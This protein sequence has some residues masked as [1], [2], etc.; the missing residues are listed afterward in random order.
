MKVYRRTFNP[1][2][3]L[4]KL[5][6]SAG[7][8]TKASPPLSTRDQHRPADAKFFVHSLTDALDLHHR[9]C[10][11]PKAM[12]LKWCTPPRGLAASPFDLVWA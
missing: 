6:T 10:T 11:P 1:L 8:R 9:V 12:V 5:N 2:I 7:F 4:F 3:A